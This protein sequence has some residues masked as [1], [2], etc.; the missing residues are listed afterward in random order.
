[1]EKIRIALGVL[2]GIIHSMRRAFLAVLFMSLATTGVARVAD[3]TIVASDSGQVDDLPLIE[4]PAVGKDSTCFAVVISGDGG[5]G[6]VER[7]LGNALAR[8]G[9]PVVG[10]SAFKYFWK[11][12]TP[13]EAG[14]DL[15]RIIRHYM[16]VWKKDST[17]LIGNSRGADVLPFMVNRLSSDLLA[18][19]SVVALVV[20]QRTIDFQFHILDW[21]GSPARKTDLPVGPEVQKLRGV[22]VLC[23]YGDQESESLCRYLDPAA[24]TVICIKGGHHLDGNYEALAE[25]ILSHGQK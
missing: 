19:V 5:W 1:V 20:P 6:T 12:R 11:R 14:R 16:A 23:V 24:V 22:K 2:R 8:R 10:M 4:V 13:D 3:D 17:I 21:F 15:E 25:I 9:V 7:Q 18:R